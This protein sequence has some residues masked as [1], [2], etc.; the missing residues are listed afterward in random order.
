VDLSKV[1]YLDISQDDVNTPLDVVLACDKLGVD[2]KYMLQAIPQYVGVRYPRL[3]SNSTI[4]RPLVLSPR[5]SPR[6]PHS[7]SRRAAYLR[8]TIPIIPE[9]I[10]TMRSISTLPRTRAA[11]SNTIGGRPS[12]TTASP[13][14]RE[15]KP[16]QGRERW[17]LMSPD[18]G[19]IID[20]VMER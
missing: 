3:W 20:R 1:P 2:A 19:D 8:H 9:T 6:D 10:R 15:P 18:R 12:R 4:R 17:R 7:R 14:K 5:S 13:A 11:R 16:S